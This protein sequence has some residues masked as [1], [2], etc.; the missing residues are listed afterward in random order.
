MIE[1]SLAEIAAAVGGR[2]DGDPT[3]RVTGAAFV[4]SRSVVPGGLT[5]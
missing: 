4:D 1:M 2:V 5:F 3:V